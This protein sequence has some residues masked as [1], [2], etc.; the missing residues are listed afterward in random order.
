MSKAAAAAATSVERVVCSA[1]FLPACKLIWCSVVAICTASGRN[2]MSTKIATIKRLKANRR[3]HLAHLVFS[4]R[5]RIFSIAFNAAIDDIANQK[6]C[7]TNFFFP[8]CPS[9]RTKKF[10]Q[11]IF[12]FEKSLKCLQ[13][14]LCKHTDYISLERGCLQFFAHMLADFCDAYA[15]LNGNLK[16]SC[17]FS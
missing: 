9:N 15:N 11:K 7:S 1:A 13:Y 8:I 16:V 10:L 14:K 17:D 12:R 6:S 3:R 2:E 4:R 5:H